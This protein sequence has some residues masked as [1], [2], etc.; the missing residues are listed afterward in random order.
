MFISN[1]VKGEAISCQARD[2]KHTYTLSLWVFFLGAI[3]NSQLLSLA[4][5]D[6]RRKRKRMST[7]EASVSA[8]TGLLCRSTFALSGRPTM[9]WLSAV[10]SQADPSDLVSL[11]FVQCATAK[12]SLSV[13]CMSPQHSRVCG[14]LFRSNLSTH[15][16]FA[17]A[18]SSFLFSFSFFFPVLFICLAAVYLLLLL[19]FLV[20]VLRKCAHSGK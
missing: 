2:N 5:A 9:I 12:C 20:T 3:Y 1:A 8:F 15:F 10:I 7:K 6:A 11:C 18:S 13:L 19:H 16:L 17:E 14:L 4:I